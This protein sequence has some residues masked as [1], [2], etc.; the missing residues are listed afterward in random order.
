[1]VTSGDNTVIVDSDDMYIVEDANVD[2]LNV[3]YDDY[4]QP[5]IAV[6]EFE[7][8]SYWSSDND[9][10]VSVQPS[11]SNEA[12]VVTTPSDYDYVT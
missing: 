9:L 11:S 7:D 2:S 1:M 10:I 6:V 12:I 4:G 8:Q 5:S 3:I